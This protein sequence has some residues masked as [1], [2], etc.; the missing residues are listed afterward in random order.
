VSK[1]SDELEGT[2]QSP[3]HQ[4]AK[5]GND[6]L[7]RD[8]NEEN[9]CLVEDA[10]HSAGGRSTFR[11][12]EKDP[13]RHLERC[14]SQ[15]GGPNGTAPGLKCGGAGHEAAQPSCGCS[16][17]ERGDVGPEPMARLGK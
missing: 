14:Q 1:L 11:S 16:K 13:Y 7:H 9:G 3:K 8:P 2:R 10:A 4:G 5:G 17:R 15:D 6:Q 12:L